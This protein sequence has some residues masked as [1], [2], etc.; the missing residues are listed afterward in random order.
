MG[1]VGWFVRSFVFVRSFFHSFVWSFVVVE[2]HVKI[3]DK[4][5][6]NRICFSQN[7]SKKKRRA[8]EGCRWPRV[9]KLDSAYETLRCVQGHSQHLFLWTHE[10]TLVLADNMGA[11]LA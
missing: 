7:Q 5:T 3:D 10:A 9:H 2:E 8:L 4:Q 6:R 11:G 1:F